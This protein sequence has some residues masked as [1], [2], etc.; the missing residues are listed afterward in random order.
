MLDAARMAERFV[1]RHEAPDAI[2][3]STAKRALTTARF[4]ATAL[5]NMAI[6]ETRDIYHAD[7]HALEAILRSFP[8]GHNSVMIFGHNPGFSELVD[9]LASGGPG[10]LS[11]CTTVRI[12]LAVEHWDEVARGMGHIQWWESPQPS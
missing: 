8:D 11:P 4:F 10:H 7:L 3:S 12:D 2:V 6:H 5:G 1:E 9:L